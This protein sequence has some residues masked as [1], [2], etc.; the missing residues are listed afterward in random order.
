MMLT[1]SGF[2]CVEDADALSTCLPDSSQ[3]W[4]ASGVGR[5]F[6]RLLPLGGTAAAQGWI[7]LNEKRWFAKGLFRTGT[8]NVASQAFVAQAFGCPC[9]REGS[10][11]VYT[12]YQG[13]IAS[14]AGG[15]PFNA[16]DC[17]YVISPDAAS[18]A[19]RVEIYGLAA[20]KTVITVWD[21]AKYL[22]QHASARLSAS[23]ALVKEALRCS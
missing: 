13:T 7:Q 15:V 2:G 4:R 18:V 20:Y 10:S 16:F 8:N 17:F 9:A 5:G 23:F 11:T 12:D 19:I 6:L 22:G 14:H 1:E 3:F 21:D